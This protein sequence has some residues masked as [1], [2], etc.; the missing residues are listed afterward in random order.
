MSATS[1]GSKE[2]SAAA[3][4]SDGSACMDQETDLKNVETAVVSEK[5]V[6]R[7]MSHQTALL[8]LS[9]LKHSLTIILTSTRTYQPSLQVRCRK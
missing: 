4:T 9:Y 2:S 6:I 7:E 1:Q 5:I 3:G 8:T